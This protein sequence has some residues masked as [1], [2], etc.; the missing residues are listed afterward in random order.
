MY[1]ANALPGI[2]F[3]EGLPGKK[4]GETIGESKGSSNA[5]MFSLAIARTKGELRDRVISLFQVKEPLA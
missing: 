5:V 2:V 1:S 3:S 4:A